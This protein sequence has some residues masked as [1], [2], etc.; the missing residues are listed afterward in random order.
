MTLEW[1]RGPPVEQRMPFWVPPPPP[2]FPEL[3]KRLCAIP[4]RFVSKFSPVRRIDAGHDSDTSCDGDQCLDR[5]RQIL[6]IVYICCSVFLLG[7]ADYFHIF[8]ACTDATDEDNPLQSL[9][10]AAYFPNHAPGRFG[11][12]PCLLSNGRCSGETEWRSMRCDGWCSERQVVPMRDM[13]VGSGPYR[14]DS[15][16][17]LAAVHAG[18]IG[19][20]GGCVDVRIGPRAL[21]FVGSTRNGVR[22]L[23]FDSYFPQTL[24]LRAAEGATHCGYDAWWG[25][26]MLHLVLFFGLAIL[27]PPRLVA[28]WCTMTALY[29]YVALAAGMTHISMHLMFERMGGFAFFALTAHAMLWEVGGAKMY[30][31]DTARG[32]PFDLLLLVVLPSLPFLHINLVG[33]ATGDYSINSAL[34][35]DWRGPLVFSLGLLA[36]TP[37]ILR[38][39][40]HWYRAGFLRQLVLGFGAGCCGFVAL[41]LLF[42]YEDWGPH[43]HHYFL[44]LLGYLA[45]RGHTRVAAVTRNLALG[46]LIHGLCIWGAPEHIPL[47]QEG[48]GW[49]PESE[50]V[51]LQTVR[52]AARIGTVLFTDVRVRALG[53]AEALPAAAAHGATEALSEGPSL[54]VFSAGPSA[55]PSSNS[56]G[57]FACRGA[58]CS[59]D[60]YTENEDWRYFSQSS[61]TQLECERACLA[62]ADC[63]GYEWPLDGSHCSFWLTSSC[64]VSDQN[65]SESFRT[66]TWPARRLS[67][68]TSAGEADGGA[69]GETSGNSSTST[70]TGTRQ[71]TLEWGLLG[72]IASNC[73][74][75][76]VWED[77]PSMYI[78]EMNHLEVYRG[79]GRK[80]TVTLPSDA[81]YFFRV[82][83]MEAAWGNGV[84]SMTPILAVTASDQPTA[85]YYN[86]SAD[87]CNRA[88]VLLHQPLSSLDGFYD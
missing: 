28:F 1:L 85:K 75:P 80:V 5:R 14:S 24:E 66:C 12:S 4:D 76:E 73:T 45:A 9:S 8:A 65:E 38:L 31:P 16:I 79:R 29:W 54:Q 70:G 49:Y 81:R 10:C 68:N 86:D 33:F 51:R 34:F 56:T 18:L 57:A 43:L 37:L 30:F 74:H 6:L 84:A 21:S 64:E 32:A 55:G 47:W 41:T 78:L 26:L 72:E 58:V 39:L 61:T 36:L 52:V 17:C 23:S 44:G 46:A 3:S 27:R 88:E 7:I 83:R 67:Q 60:A 40:W 2:L 53:G 35:Q 62:N 77:D 69:A 50:G 22:S 13:V 87:I 63:T 20:S 11:F 19:N 59:W 71:V 82:G 15:R 25:I 42:S 48:A